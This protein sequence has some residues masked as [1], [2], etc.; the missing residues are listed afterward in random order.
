MNFHD[1]SPIFF[2]FFFFF[3]NLVFFCPKMILRIKIEVSRNYFYIRAIGLLFFKRATIFCSEV[4]SCSKIMQVQH[5]LSRKTY[6]MQFLEQKL[7]TLV[8]PV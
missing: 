8:K 7:F 3:V 2:F 5:L 4:C 1:I 6:T